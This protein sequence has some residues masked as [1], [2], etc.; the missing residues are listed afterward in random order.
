VRDCYHHAERFLQ[1]L[2]VI[3]PQAVGRA[4]TPERR[5]ALEDALRDFAQCAARLFRPG[6]AHGLG[7]DTEDAEHHGRIA[8]LA[9]Q[10][11]ADHRLGID[12]AAEL[13]HRAARL[14]MLYARHT[15]VQTQESFPAAAPAPSAADVPQIF[16]ELT[17]E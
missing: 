17:A 15:A 9:R 2:T 1:T 12:R 4:L 5:R 11:L 14:R 13:R 3:D 16:R 7:S 6:H 8:S 10:W